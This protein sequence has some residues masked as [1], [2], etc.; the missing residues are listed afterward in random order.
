M[1]NSLNPDQAP[2]FVGPDIGPNCLQKLIFT[3]SLLLP[4]MKSTFLSAC[5]AHSKTLS[6]YM[7]SKLCL[8]GVTSVSNN[9]F[10]CFSVFYAF[11]FLHI[12]TILCSGLGLDGF[13]NTFVI[14]EF[15]SFHK[16]N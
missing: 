10:L 11:I 15:I 3:F 12:A 9:G 5:I 8:G 16:E 6:Y 4:E 14:N 13:S 1:S 7:I 2:H